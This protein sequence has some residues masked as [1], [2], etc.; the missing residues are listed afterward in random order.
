MHSPPAYL[1]LT[2]IIYQEIGAKVRY[3][4]LACRVPFYFLLNFMF[5]Y[6]YNV[7]TFCRPF[8]HLPINAFHAFFLL[9]TDQHVYQSW[10][11][12][13]ERGDKVVHC[14]NLNY[15][16]M[17]KCIIIF[18]LAKKQIVHLAILTITG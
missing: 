5:L 16:L 18:Y 14:F 3:D 9:L 13:G 12:H 4:E 8:D 7:A 6:I 1:D 15:A 2:Y 10:G 11:G 17:F